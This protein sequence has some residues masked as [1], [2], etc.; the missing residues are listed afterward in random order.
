MPIKASFLR[1][2]TGLRKDISFLDSIGLNISW[3]SV[4]VSIGFIGFYLTVLPTMDGV[5]L[6][7]MTL[8]ATVLLIPQSVLCWGIHLS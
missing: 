5:N 1:D 2:A 8:I 7:Y 4:M 3:S 6:V